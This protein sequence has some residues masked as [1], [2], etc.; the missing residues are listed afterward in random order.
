VPAPLRDA[1]A[2]AE[3]LFA[4]SQD[5]LG[6]ADAAGREW[7]DDPP[8]ELEAHGRQVSLSLRSLGPDFFLALLAPVG[9][10]T[11]AGAI[12]LDAAIADLRTRLG[13]PPESADV[14]FTAAPFTAA[15]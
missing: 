6:A 5:L 10:R 2:H 3:R 11:E 13:A 12:R 4:L 15:R 8:V 7:A 9:M 14:A 1:D